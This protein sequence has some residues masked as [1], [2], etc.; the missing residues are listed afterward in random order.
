MSQQPQSPVQASPA[1]G[2]DR[3]PHTRLL[4][5]TGMSGAGKSSALKVLEDLGYEAVDN[6]PIGLLTKLLATEDTA[7][8]QDADR[9]IAL[10]IDSR[11]RAFDAEQIVQTLKD[12][13][14]KENIE[15]SVLFLD[16]SGEE[17]SRRFSETR[18]RHPLAL[19]RP[20]QDGIAR[21]RELLAPL[22]R[23]ADVVLDTTQYSSRQLQ[24]ALA[25]RFALSRSSSMTLTLMS[26][27]YAR[28]IPRDADLVFDMRFLSNP[29]WVDDLRPL[30]GLDEGVGHYIETDPNFAPAFAKL[31]DV[32]SY[33][34]PLYRKE[35][36]A[37]LT[38]AFGC[39]GGKHRSVFVTER[40]A[41]VL[42]GEGHTLSIVHRDLR[43][44]T[45]GAEQTLTDKAESISV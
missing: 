15:V 27:G 8:E 7:S 17:L 33:L 30:T 11:T 19:D 25:S 41:A 40:M 44:Q 42:R 14:D 9:P 6:L 39:T 21:E 28:G 18:R 3:Q 34:I 24:H 1:Q 2:G 37:Y 16:C 36:K 29:H 31:H 45:S 23:W 35:G 13:R 26:F 4:L 38:V 22:R 12:L 10:G 32:I 43:A 5:V 20:V